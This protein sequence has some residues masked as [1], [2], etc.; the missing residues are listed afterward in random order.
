M[1]LKKINQTSSIGGK[2][3]SGWSNRSQTYEIIGWTKMIFVSVDAQSLVKQMFCWNWNELTEY[4]LNT[5]LAKMKPDMK[6][7][8]TDKH[9]ST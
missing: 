1:L 7:Y 4:N 3:W 5:P 9:S 2:Q 8:K 6:P